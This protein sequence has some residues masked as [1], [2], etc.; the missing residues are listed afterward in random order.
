M[1]D[2]CPPLIEHGPYGWGTSCTARTR[3]LGIVRKR[4]SSGEEMEL[5][6]RQGFDPATSDPYASYEL[7]NATVVPR[8]IAWISTMPSGGVD[9]EAP[10]AYY[11]IASIRPPISQF[12]SF[13][14]KGT[15]ANIESSGQFVVNLAPVSLIDRVNA[16]ATDFPRSASEFEEVGVDRE[17]SVVVKPP[18]VAGSPTRLEPLTGSHRPSSASATSAWLSVAPTAGKAVARPLRRAVCTG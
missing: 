15:L 2:G 16:S 9:N 1:P 10:H 12:A 4:T 6:M 14:W 13:G 8:A 18:R 11:N 17:P 3:T 5:P 7:L